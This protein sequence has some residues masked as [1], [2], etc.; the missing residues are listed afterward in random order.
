MV[1]RMLSLCIASVLFLNS[2]LGWATPQE[3]ASTAYTPPPTE[4]ESPPPPQ[5]DEEGSEVERVGE[6]RQ[7]IFPLLVLVEIL[8]GALAAGGVI[9]GTLVNAGYQTHHPGDPDPFWN[10]KNGNPPRR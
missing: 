8:V 6:A 9:G 3:K 10:D 7:N 4:E 5:K 2:A 1:M